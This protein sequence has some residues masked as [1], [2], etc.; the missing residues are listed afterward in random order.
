MPTQ[1]W[2]H[3]AAC[4]GQDP[5]IWFPL[6]IDAVGDARAVC[7]ECPV[8]AQCAALATSARTTDGVFAGFYLPTERRQLVEYATGKPHRPLR[9]CDDCGKEFDTVNNLQQCAE[10]RL[11][12]RGDRVSARPVQAHID[13]L[14][15]VFDVGYGQ[16]GQAA[17]LT[18][19]AV[20]AVASPRTKTVRREVADAILAV[21]SL[22]P[23]QTKFTAAGVG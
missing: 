16:I 18:K 20:V 9:K 23:K 2:Q 15:E 4:R 22:T 12:A 8:R 11:L 13:A 6:N 3:R 17:G 5:E 19:S 21:V 14:R 1:T 10:C 7:F